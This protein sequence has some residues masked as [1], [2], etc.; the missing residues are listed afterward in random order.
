MEIARSRL[1]AERGVVFARR[2][3]TRAAEAGGE[4]HR[5]VDWVSFRERAASGGYLLWWE[6]HGLGYGLPAELANELKAG[7]VVVANASRT[8]V[9]AA[10]RR[11]GRVRIVSVTAGPDLIAARLAG[12]GRETAEE[13]A[14]RSARRLDETLE[15]PDLV[16]RND[17]PAELAGEALATAI[18]GW[19]GRASP[20]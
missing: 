16:L 1:S 14:E 6:A 18:R 20:P 17:G 9:G 2:D 8:V 15:P 13:I 5:P 4:T 7:R 10:R 3:I 19:A 12:R 11:F